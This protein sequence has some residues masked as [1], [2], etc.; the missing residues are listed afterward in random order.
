MLPAGRKRRLIVLAKLLIP[1]T[2]RP[3]DGFSWPVFQ[4]GF[5]PCDCPDFSRFGLPALRVSGDRFLAPRFPHRSFRPSRFCSREA[6]KARITGNKSSGPVLAGIN[7]GFAIRQVRVFPTGN[8]VIR[9]WGQ[10]VG[11]KPS[12]S[13]FPEET[14]GFSS[15]VEHRVPCWGRVTSADNTCY[16]KTLRANACVKHSIPLGARNT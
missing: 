8:D 12:G 3:R 1:L 2:V 5:L 9:A 13:V 10:Q 15:I 16:H 7:E 14:P 6:C 4:L 11:G